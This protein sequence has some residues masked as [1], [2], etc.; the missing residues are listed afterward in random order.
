MLDQIV[1]SLVISSNPEILLDIFRF[2]IKLVLIQPIQDLVGLLSLL[3]ERPVDLRH[4]GL[5][6]IGV[7]QF[8]L[9][10]S[11]LGSRATQNLAFCS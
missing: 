5:V 2:L 6:V 10:V 7:R 1:K 3:V 4:R 11:C 9:E 8:W